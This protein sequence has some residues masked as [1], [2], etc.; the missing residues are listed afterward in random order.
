[1]TA[2]NNS[3]AR[4]ESLDD[5]NYYIIFIF[6]IY[7]IYVPLNLF[8]TARCERTFEIITY[9]IAYFNIYF[10]FFFDHFSFASFGV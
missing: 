1:M 5:W 7:I 2:D 9:S 8:F 4:I 6:D 10:T 3:T